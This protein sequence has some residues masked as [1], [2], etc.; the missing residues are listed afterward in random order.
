MKSLCTMALMAA[1]GFPP[2]LLADAG[3][4]HGEAPAAPAGPAAPRFESHSELFELVGVLENGKLTLYLDR[5]R[6]NAPVANA[7]LE[8]DSEA[9][10]GEAAPAAEGVYT[11][12]GAP[13]ARPGRHALTFT[14][15]AAEE[16]DLL[17]GVLEVAPAD[18]APP[19]PAMTRQFLQS[20]PLAAGVAAF[21]VAMFFAGRVR[22]GVRTR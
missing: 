7:R 6:D 17:N 12:P 18:R 5:Y 22:R 20:W 3:H 2:A 13:F 19:A 1:L 10:K 8:V 15:T 4:D 9:F 16:T 21:G 14:V 11:L